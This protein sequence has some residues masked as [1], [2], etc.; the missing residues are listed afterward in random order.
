MSREKLAAKLAV[1][2]WE[3]EGRGGAAA[4]GGDGDAA[5]A[6]FEPRVA[7]SLAD[8]LGLRAFDESEINRALAD[9]IFQILIIYLAPSEINFSLPSENL[10][11]VKSIVRKR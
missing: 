1:L 3:L 7:R 8:A 11:R 4:A 2:Q 5:P 10:E 6:K 9:F